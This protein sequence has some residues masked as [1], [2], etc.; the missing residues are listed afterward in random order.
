[1]PQARFNDDE[2]YQHVFANQAQVDWALRIWPSYASL[3]RVGV[4]QSFGGM[5]LNRM[6]RAGVSTA[7]APLQ[8]WW[9][10]EVANLPG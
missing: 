1:M 2:T 10:P 6:L 4:T 5:H 9:E 8:R 7:R 3:W